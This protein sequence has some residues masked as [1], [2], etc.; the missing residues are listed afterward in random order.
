MPQ[1]ISNGFAKDL[2]AFFKQAS[3]L[4]GRCPSCGTPFRLSEA[5]ISARQEPPADW[6]RRLE[7]KE[8]AL[9]SQEYEV[10]E[11]ELLLAERERELKIREREVQYGEDRLEQNSKQRVREILKSKTE[12]QSLIREASKDAVKRSRATLLGRMLE[13]LAP[14]FH[15]FAYDPRDMRS[16]CDPYD[17]VLF[18]GLTVERRV[19]DITF[20][21][22]KC[23]MGRETSVQRSLREAVDEK[24][25]FAEV[26][27][28]GNPDI[29]ITKQ[30][31][32]SS[33][34]ALPPLLE[35]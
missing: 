33:R 17:Y 5:A 9:S 32:R 22:I 15:K 31:P 10:S 7:R 14:C 26:W 3:H 27:E 23:G 34:R 18:N 6:L 2:V 35:E 1:S 30:L 8:A 24:R 11:R 21:E 29:P 28:I 12:V 16:I 4:W 13:R 20:I 19:K 25:V